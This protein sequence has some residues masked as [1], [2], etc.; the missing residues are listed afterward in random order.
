M[1]GHIIACWSCLHI[2]KLIL[3]QCQ[4]HN[5]LGGAIKLQLVGLEVRG[6]PKVGQF[7]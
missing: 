2:L 3:K 6:D 7:N 4:Y 5:L 1:H